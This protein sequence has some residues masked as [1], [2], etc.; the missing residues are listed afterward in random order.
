MMADPFD[1]Q[2]RLAEINAERAAK[3]MAAHQ[4]AEQ[5]LK[6]A[7]MPPRMQRA[8]QVTCPCCSDCT[9]LMVPVNKLV[10]T[11]G[12]FSEPTKHM[13]SPTLHNLTSAWTSVNMISVCMI[14]QRFPKAASSVEPQSCNTYL[15]HQ[16]KYVACYP[17]WPD[18]KPGWLFA[19]PAF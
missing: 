9:L 19:R 13:T 15:S 3:K 1:M 14:S 17:A 4:A 12:R 16:Q 18:S 7:A 10:Q 11:T 5:K 8:A 6:E 2:E